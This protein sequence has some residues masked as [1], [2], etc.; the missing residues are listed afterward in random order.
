MRAWFSRFPGH[1]V[2]CQHTFCAFLLFLCQPETITDPCTR[3]L[4]PTS[5]GSWRGTWWCL[6]PLSFL[7]FQKEVSSFHPGAVCELPPPQRRLPF[8]SFL[9]CQPLSSLWEQTTCLQA[10]LATFPTPFFGLQLS[11]SDAVFFS[12]V[13]WMREEMALR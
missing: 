13:Y 3:K 4:G 8:A 11:S 2:I 1:S 5:K 12:A 9:L 7:L 6:L 10:T